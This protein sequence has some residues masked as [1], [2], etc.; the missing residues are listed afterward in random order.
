M[1]DEDFERRMDEE[2]IKLAIAFDES[3]GKLNFNQFIEKYASDE[4]KKF[5]KEYTEEG[6]RLR[7]QGIFI[8]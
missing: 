1:N 5:L 8:N 2:G 7:E 3:D 4:Y 6:M